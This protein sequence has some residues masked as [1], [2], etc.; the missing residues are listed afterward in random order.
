[1]KE[2]DDPECTF[3]PSLDPE[4]L[5]IAPKKKSLYERGMEAKVYR[6][7]TFKEQMLAMEK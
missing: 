6:K 3:R 4:S 7:K 5:Q 2:D 1:M